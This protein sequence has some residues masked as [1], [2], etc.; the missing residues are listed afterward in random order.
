M[1]TVE[2]PMEPENLLEEDLDFEDDED[3]DCEAEDWDEET[4]GLEVDE[5]EVQ[6]ISRE[7]G[8]R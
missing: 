6:D 1:S 8:L 3:F 4:L 7:I 5:M 2:E